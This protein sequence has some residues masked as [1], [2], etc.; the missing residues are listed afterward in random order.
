MHDIKYDGKRDD[1]GR[2]VCSIHFHPI[3]PGL[4]KNLLDP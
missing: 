1:K 4:P 3:A 2:L